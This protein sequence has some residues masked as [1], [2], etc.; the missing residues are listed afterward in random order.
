MTTPTSVDADVDGPSGLTAAFET[1]ITHSY[2]I[3]LHDGAQ[4]FISWLR[5]DNEDSL[6]EPFD[7][8]LPELLAEWINE[9]LAS[10]EAARAE[11]MDNL[12]AGTAN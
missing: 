11:A 5:G 6:V 9:T 10:V 7:G 8:D 4:L 1:A 2:Q 12:A 3:G